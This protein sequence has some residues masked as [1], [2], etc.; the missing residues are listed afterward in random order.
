[1]VDDPE[2]L[3][4]T[5]WVSKFTDEFAVFPEGGHDDIMDAIVGAYN[6]MSGKKLTSAVIGGSKEVQDIMHG[7]GEEVAVDLYS[8]AT[9]G[10]STVSHVHGKKFAKEQ[11]RQLLRGLGPNIKF[12]VGGG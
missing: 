5:P 12:T 7:E 10:R 11:Q 9:F 2:D 6:N 4:A 3:N 1:V 8:S